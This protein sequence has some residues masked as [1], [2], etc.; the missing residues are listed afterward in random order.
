MPHAEKDVPKAGPTK[1]EELDGSSKTFAKFAIGAT[2]QDVTPRMRD[3]LQNLLADWIAVVALA[4]RVADSSRP[5]LEAVKAL[6]LGAPGSATVVGSSTKLP[7][8]YA[9]LMNGAYAHS[10]DFDG[11]QIDG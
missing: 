10:L 7:K 9:A 8:Q 11:K 2:L 3:T 1:I 5:F 6:A 4:A